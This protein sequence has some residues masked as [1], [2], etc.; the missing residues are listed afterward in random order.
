MLLFYAMLCYTLQ[1]AVPELIFL[2]K[3]YQPKG[4]DDQMVLVDPLE[5]DKSDTPTTYAHPWH[6]LNHGPAYNHDHNHSHGYD[7]HGHSS[8]EP[9][10]GPQHF[11][12]MGYSSST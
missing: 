8:Y 11:M 10:F 2:V 6:W 5:E 12:H 7:S 1:G 3:S 9:D 4:H